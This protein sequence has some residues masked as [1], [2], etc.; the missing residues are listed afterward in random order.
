MLSFIRVFKGPL[1]FIFPHYVMKD[2]PNH[3]TQGRASRPTGKPDKNTS[4][5][6]DCLVKR[7][8]V[9]L[10]TDFENV[11]ER[12][13]AGVHLCVFGCARY[14]GDAGIGVLKHHA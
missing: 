5:H 9:P 12:Q 8:R 7:D 14:V 3:F 1:R 13:D 10:K 11:S 2:N 6:R 4:T